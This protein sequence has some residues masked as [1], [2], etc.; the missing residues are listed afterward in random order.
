MK[1]D[2]SKVLD[3]VI[4]HAVWAPPITGFNAPHGYTK[5]V[6]IIKLDKKKFQQNFKGNVIDLGAC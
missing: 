2:W 3:H 4:G 6:C 1:K 5:D